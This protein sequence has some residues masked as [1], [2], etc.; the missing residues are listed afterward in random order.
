M[1]TLTLYC[2]A[3]NFICRVKMTIIIECFQHHCDHCDDWQRVTREWP[4][5]EITQPRHNDTLMTGGL[6]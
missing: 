4:E 1:H 2:Q 3:I 5:T 6:G